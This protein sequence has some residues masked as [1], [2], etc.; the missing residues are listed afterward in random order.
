MYYL[1]PIVTGQVLD[2]DT[3]E[4]L[5]GVT[6]VYTSK[7]LAETDES[8]FF[9][10]PP[11]EYDVSSS[12]DY[13]E[14]NQLSESSMSVYKE[15]YR[16]K[17]YS[18]FDFPRIRISRSSEVPEYIHIGKIYLKRLPTD[19]ST[20]DVEDEFI[21]DMTFCQPNESQKEVNCIPV[22]EGVSREDI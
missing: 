17:Y 2:K 12:T 5:G 22:P 6:I 3:S 8:G 7:E 19:V 15:T 20:N 9:K 16:R 18:N 10:L 21:E 11:I 1:T 4:P 14:L 13:W